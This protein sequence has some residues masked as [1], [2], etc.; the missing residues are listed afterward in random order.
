MPAD[1]YKIFDV[2]VDGEFV[3]PVSA[4]TFNNVS[5]NHR[6]KA[7]FTVDFDVQDNTVVPE[8]NFTVNATVLGSAITNGP[9]G[10][11]LPVTCRLKIGNHTYTPWGDYTKALD[12]N[13]NDGKNPRFW[14]STISFKAGTPVRI[15]ACSWLK[16]GKDPQKT[17]DGLNA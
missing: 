7:S 6:I 10:Y 12:G 1:N 4:Y 3:G 17:I 2:L 14:E 5:S 11:N 8:N 13:L 16:N 15:E 9:N